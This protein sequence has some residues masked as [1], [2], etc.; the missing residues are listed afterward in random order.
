[1]DNPNRMC[2]VVGGQKELDWAAAGV[3]I[4]GWPSDTKALAGYYGDELRVVVLYNTFFDGATC[5][6]HVC[7]KPG[8]LWAT[9]ATLREFF[10]YPFIQLG[11]RRVTAPIAGRNIKSQVLALKLGFKQE[12]R[13]RHA[14]KDDDE[15]LLGLVREDCKWTRN[16]HG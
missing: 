10:A 1:M 5:S 15:V 8:A 12:G 11:L 14:R 4:D 6:M 13:L 16:R 9:P 3:G 2:V 7:A